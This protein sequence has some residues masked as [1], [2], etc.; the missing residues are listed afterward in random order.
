[1]SAHFNTVD[2]GE[3]SLANIMTVRT[4][5]CPDS[6]QPSLQ[7]EAWSWRLRAMAAA[8][9]MTSATAIGP[10]TASVVAIELLPAELAEDV[11][12]DVAR[13]TDDDVA[14]VVE[15][16]TVVAP[17]SSIPFWIVTCADWS[18]PAVMLP[19]TVFVDVTVPF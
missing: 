7:G 16:V 15:V 12:D 14:D 3:A 5:L 6:S 1:M 2:F 13:A 9:R 4:Q 19:S 10:N 18:V 11:T 17:T 8:T